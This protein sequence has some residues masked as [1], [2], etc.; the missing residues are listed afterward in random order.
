M[1]FCV[2]AYDL[3]LAIVT[4]VFFVVYNKKVDKWLLTLAQVI[5]REL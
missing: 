4:E 5:N 2:L 3:S 1:G